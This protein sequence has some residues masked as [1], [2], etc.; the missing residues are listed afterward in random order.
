MTQEKHVQ[1][2]LTNLQE[3]AEKAKKSVDDGLKTMLK[4]EVDVKNFMNA[5]EQQRVDLLVNSVPETKRIT[6]VF[7][8]N[9]PNTQVKES[10]YKHKK[11]H[12]DVLEDILSKYDDTKDSSFYITTELLN[13]NLYKE[14]EDIFN[15]LV[16]D[17]EGNQIA[18]ESVKKYQEEVQKEQSETI[19]IQDFAKDTVKSL[20]DGIEQV[21]PVLNILKVITKNPV[22]RTILESLEQGAEIVRHTVE[23]KEE[24][25]TKEKSETVVNT[26]KEKSKQV[27]E[28]VQQKTPELLDKTKEFIKSEK[29]E[30]VKT[31]ASKWF[32]KLKTAVSDTIEDI[33]TKSNEKEVQSD[34]EEYNPFMA[35]IDE[36]MN[37]P[38]D[39]YHEKL[40]KELDEKA[41]KVQE[42]QAEFYSNPKYQM[43]PATKDILKQFNQKTQ[44]EIDAFYLELNALKE[45]EKTHELSAIESLRLGQLKITEYLYKN[46]IQKEENNNLKEHKLF[47]KKPNKVNN[48]TTLETDEEKEIRLNKILNSVPYSLDEKDNEPRIEL[49]KK[50]VHSVNNLPLSRVDSVVLANGRKRLISEP[51]RLEIKETLGKIIL[52]DLINNTTNNII[53]TYQVKF[54]DDEVANEIIALGIAYKRAIPHDSELDMTNIPPFKA[55]VNN[56][57]I[58]Y[59]DAKTKEVKYGV[60]TDKWDNEKDGEIIEVLSDTQYTLEFID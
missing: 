35:E 39:A 33:S 46:N 16:D 38:K 14:N 24:S 8:E 50:I 34:T 42:T 23:P 51:I 9:H 28:T 25:A 21:K 36:L 5:L 4:A 12:L 45:K 26:I 58:S 56:V 41:K 48:E 54:A 10:F 1:D 17:L 7:I 29:V 57:A 11:E 49:I 6:D 52:V 27:Q 2:I 59:K 32:G 37:K 40:K 47:N 55:L 13:N 60:F 30:N 53:S 3:Q 18:L 43:N 31:T 19:S 15:F 22:H 20:A 44:E